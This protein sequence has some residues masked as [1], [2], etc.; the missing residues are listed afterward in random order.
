MS[1]HSRARAVAD[2]APAQHAIQGVRASRTVTPGHRFA[3]AQAFTGQRSYSLR[4][5]GYRV[6]VRHRTRDVA[7]LSE[8]F[9]KRSYSPPAGCL[10]TRPFTVLDL[11]GNIG[12]F[13]LFAFSEWPVRSIRSY[14]PD[15]ENALL[16]RSVAAPHANWDVVEAAVSNQAG[17]MRFRAGLYSESRAATD[18]EPATQVRMVDVFAEP[19]ADLVKMDIE[20]GEWPI[21]HDPRLPGLADVIVLEWHKGGCRTR[22]PHATARQLLADAGYTR[23]HDAVHEHEFNGLLWAWKPATGS[24]PLQAG[25][26]PRC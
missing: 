10:P 18:G 3:A 6:T 2:T 25:D 5:S 20:G 21:L 26:P 15:P 7:I 9:A 14:E 17:T 4:A 24:P 19:R 22:D 1:I 8:I 12:L 16:L 11:G 23:Q 13:G